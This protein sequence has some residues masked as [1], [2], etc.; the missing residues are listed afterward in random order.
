MSIGLYFNT[1][2]ASV[3]GNQKVH[4]SHWSS[5]DSCPFNTLLN[6]SYCLAF[7]LWALLHKSFSFNSCL[8]KYK[9]WKCIADEFKLCKNCVKGRDFSLKS[10]GQK[11]VHGNKPL[12]LHYKY[13][14]W[15]RGNYYLDLTWPHLSVL[16]RSLTWESQYKVCVLSMVVRSGQAEAGRLV[17][18]LLYAEPS[19]SGRFALVGC[20]MWHLWFMT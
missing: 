5:V 7:C 3:Y 4:E 16:P 6:R 12:A 2:S 20:S 10:F 15:G 18:V 19:Q 17:S 8:G 14:F 13:I 1:S 9:R 11:C